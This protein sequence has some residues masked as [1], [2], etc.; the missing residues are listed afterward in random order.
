[1]PDRRA[2][3]PRRHV[4]ARIGRLAE[5]GRHRHALQDHALRR[6]RDLPD[7]GG[8]PAVGALQVPRAP[9]RARGR[10]DPREHAARARLDH[11]RGADPGRADRRHLPLPR[12]HREPAAV[13]PERAP[14][15]EL[16]V[17]LDRPARPAPERRPV[18]AHRGERPAV[19][20]A[21]RLSR[22]PVAVQLPRDGRAGG[23]HGGPRGHGLRRHPLLVDPEAGRQGRRRARPRE[24]DLVQDPRQVRGRQ[25]RGG[26]RLRRPVRRALRRGPR[27]HAGRGARGHA[28]PVRAVGRGAARGDRGGRRGA[29]R[30]A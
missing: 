11:G 8:H 13:R 3:G 16:D 25:L 18:P 1:M 27:R 15:L 30:A 10:A 17:R 12:R 22:R 6:D 24:R 19:P 5:R 7:R 23:H 2:G 9:H 4:L 21:L 29:R 14:G 28:R 20:V 26:H